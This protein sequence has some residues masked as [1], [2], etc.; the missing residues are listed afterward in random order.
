M[1]LAEPRAGL[2]LLLPHP[3]TKTVISNAM[4]HMSG[5]VTL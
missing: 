4:N 5:F 2:L 3:V 1:A